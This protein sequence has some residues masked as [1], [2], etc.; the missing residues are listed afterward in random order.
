MIVVCVKVGNKYGPEYVNKLRN[1]VARNTNIP[2]RFLCLTDDPNGLDVEWSPIGC[3]YPGWWSKLVL[4]KSHPALTERF[5]YL[6]LDTVIVGNLD[7][8]MRMTSWFAILKDWWA[9]SYN[10]SVMVM[11]PNSQRQVWDNFNYERDS[12]RVHGDQNIITEQAESLTILQ[13]Y[14]PAFFGSYKAN[15]LEKGPGRYR[16]VCFHGDPKPHTFEKGWVRDAWV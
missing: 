5:V 14:M 11:E 3:E 4:F 7:P 8:L 16:V 15:D 10:S 1:M 6:D 9:P 2:H 12:V 13:D